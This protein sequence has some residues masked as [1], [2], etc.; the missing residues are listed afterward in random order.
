MG[1]EERNM[2]RLFEPSTINSLQL[3]NRIVRSATYEGM[4][5]PDGSCTEALTRKMEELAEG[6]VGMIVTSH[7]FVS[8]EGRARPFQ[9]GVHDDSMTSGLGKMAGAVRAKGAKILLQLAHGGVQ[10]DAKSTG[11]PA[12]GPSDFERPDKVRAREMTAYD[13]LR[14]HTAY[15]EAAR[16]AQ[17]AGFDGVQIHAAH[18]YLLSEFL[19][20][21]FNRRTDAYGGSLENRARF[22]VETAAAVRRKT[23]RNFTILVKINSED[24]RPDGFRREE[25]FRVAEMLAE[26]GID[27]VEMSGGGPYSGDMIPSRKGMLVTEDDEV[28]Y[29]EAAVA[30]KK[31]VDLPLV[32]VGGIRSVGVAENLVESGVADY[33]ALS[34]PLIREPGLARRWREGD[35]SRSACIS[36]NLCYV[37]IL[38]GKGMYCE[39]EARELARG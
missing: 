1:D 7:A 12:M 3:P 15:E 13:I 8:P 4:A 24:F 10:A 37:P 38:E 2:S 26:A 34:R 18:N 19:S 32:L 22:L 14:L 16:R 17:E 35:R 36:C 29:R 9:L 27:A 28:Y 6:G 31:E 23:G 33:V 30:Y 11:L 20:P 39:A 21:F 25:M 5:G